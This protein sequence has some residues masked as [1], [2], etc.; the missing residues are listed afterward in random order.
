MTVAK[1]TQPLRWGGVEFEG[2]AMLNVGPVASGY[3]ELAPGLTVL[4]GLN[5]AGKSTVLSS[6]ESAFT[7][8]QLSDERARVGLV[9]RLADYPFLDSH[10]LA[11]QLARSIGARFGAS[12]SIAVADALRDSFRDIADSRPDVLNQVAEQRRFLLTPVGTKTV[13]RWLVEPVC[14][15]GSE[16]HHVQSYLRDVEDALATMSS[17]TEDGDSPAEYDPWLDDAKSL[18]ADCRLLP[19]FDGVSLSLDGAL[20]PLV[21]L[22]TDAYSSLLSLPRPLTEHVSVDEVNAQLRTFIA[23]QLDHRLSALDADADE[24]PEFLAVLNGICEPL[25][26]MATAALHGSFQTSL[27][28]IPAIHPLPRWIEHAAV[29]WA[30]VTPAGHILSL[31]K[32][33]R[34]E[35]RWA[36]LSISRIMR[37]LDQDPYWSPDVGVL[38]E[39]AFTLTLIDEPELALHRLAES[40]MA[41]A[42]IQSR[43]PSNPVVV[44]T[45]SPELIDHSSN[46]VRVR[47]DSATWEN[48]LATWPIDGLASISV[49]GL[50]KS[51]VLA[52]YRVVVAVEGVHDEWVLDEL[53]HDELELRRALLLPM[54]GGKN[55]PA[56]AT[57]EALFRLTD[58]VVLPVWDNLSAEKLS[59]AWATAIKRSEEQAGQDE[60]RRH[61]HEA[62]SGSS[63]TKFARQFMTLAL[64]ARTTDRVLTPFGM[65]ESDILHYLPPKALSSR[66]PDTW[67][68]VAREWSDS[69]SD[70]GEKDFLRRRYSLKLSEG[71]IRTAA[72]AMDSIP[73]DF[74]LLLRHIDH[75]T[76]S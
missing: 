4:Y 36:V 1:P 18:V 27:K 16:T 51:D 25:G 65:A 75:H 70:V 13:P 10:P 12:L 59:N 22:E 15:L 31:N 35:R 6:L 58:V 33:S 44:A 46:L 48:H 30:A 45:H 19:V 23:R 2:L 50:R 21:R 34:A 68:E 41:E 53:L 69:G 20:P 64:E 56:M 28:L 67:S 49:L 54:H 26:A 9:V 38:E 76:W 40:F 63:E 7:G 61:L 60:I 57:A 5:G 3:L 55:T 14:R 47:H 42:L 73:D 72:A 8:V 29:E 71:E 52:R 32:V 74:V 24:V 62:L 39:E 17:S 11:D 43:S 37:Q 66:M